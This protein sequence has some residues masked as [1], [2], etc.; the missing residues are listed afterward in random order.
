[1]EYY[2][3]DLCKSSTESS[4]AD[5]YAAIGAFLTRTDEVLHKLIPLEN[6][7]RE[8]ALENVKQLRASTSSLT[9]TDFDTK[10]VTR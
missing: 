4:Y 1:M 3:P 6:K 9:K 10:E 2:F 8:L 7:L 5:D